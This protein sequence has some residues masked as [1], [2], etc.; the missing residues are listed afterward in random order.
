MIKEKKTDLRSRYTQTVIKKS[1]LKLLA[2]SPLNKIT[3]S[4]I[5][6]E[7]KINRST[8]YNHFYDAFDV[9]ESTEN[10]FFIEVKHKLEKIKTYAADYAFFKEIM[11]FV[12]ENSDYMSVVTADIG[13]NSLLKKLIHFV[14]EKYVFEFS[15]RYPKIKKEL[16]ENIFSYTLNGSLGIVMDWIKS[17]KAQPSDKIAGY[18]QNFTACVVEKYFIM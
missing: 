5:C 15:E 6:H 12:A 8:F 10:E 13:E 4:E 3:V 11:K 18:I 14:R 17:D 16:I 1:L 9:Y 7:A 2:E